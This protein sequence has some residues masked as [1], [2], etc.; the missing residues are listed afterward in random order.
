MLSFQS[1]I[2]A[3]ITPPGKGF[4]VKTQTVYEKTADGEE[5]KVSMTTHGLVDTCD[6]K[7]FAGQ[8]RRMSHLRIWPFRL[9]Q[10]E[11]KWNVY[12]WVWPRNDKSWSYSSQEETW[13]C[14]PFNATSLC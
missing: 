5:W 10:C 7:Q 3:E 2:P 4:E 9:C 11:W 14:T 13:F 12:K 6:I 1:V 8:A